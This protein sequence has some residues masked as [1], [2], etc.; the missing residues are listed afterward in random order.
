MVLPELSSLFLV[1]SEETHW[2]PCHPASPR[3]LHEMVLCASGPLIM[4]KSLSFPISKAANSSQFTRDLTKF[5][6]KVPHPLSLGQIRKICQ[7][8]NPAFWNQ[9]GPSLNIYLVSLNLP[10]QGGWY[11]HSIYKVFS[12]QHLCPHANPLTG[13]RQEH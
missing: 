4:D 5:A 12:G 2:G 9:D 10:W 13:S 11:A 8:T 7:S 3:L 6:T 1:I